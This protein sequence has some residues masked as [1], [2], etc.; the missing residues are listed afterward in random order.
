MRA[1]GEA[2]SIEGHRGE[3][4]IRTREVESRCDYGLTI[5][6]IDDLVGIRG[7]T[8]HIFCQEDFELRQCI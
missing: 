3:I 1:G 7:K 2:R 6:E 4:S 5:I 8:I